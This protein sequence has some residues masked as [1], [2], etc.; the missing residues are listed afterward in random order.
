[1]ALDLGAETFDTLSRQSVK[2]YSS[3]RRRAS[4]AEQ[5]VL[6]EEELA[7]EKA[8]ILAE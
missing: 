6:T 3:T 8:R 7:A 5:G 1:M 2:P 4:S